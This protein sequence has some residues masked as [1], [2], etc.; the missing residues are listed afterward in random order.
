M[1]KKETAILKEMKETAYRNYFELRNTD[2]D[3]LKNSPGYNVLLDKYLS[4]ACEYI[5]LEKRLEQGA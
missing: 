3:D 5:D 4:I 2:D 1:T